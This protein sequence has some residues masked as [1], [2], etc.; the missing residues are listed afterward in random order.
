MKYLDKDGLT[1]LWGKIKAKIPTKTSQLTNDSGFSTF[2]GSYN[3]LT[4]KPTIP[5]QLSAGSHIDITNNTIKNTGV[6][7]VTESDSN[8]ANGT[9]QVLTGTSGGDITVNV[10]VKG[11]NNAAYKNV[12]TAIGSGGESLPT[13]TAVKSFVEGKGYTTNTGTITKV[14]ANGTDVAS[15]GTANIPAASTSEYGVTK[16]SSAT[17]STSTVLA[18]TPSA[19]KSAYDLASTASSKAFDCEGNIGNMDN[20][21]GGITLVDA[22]NTRQEVLTSGENIKTIDNKSLLGSG[23]LDITVNSYSISTTEP[24]SANYINSLI[25][26]SETTEYRVGIWVDDK[27]IYRKTFHVS[28]LP[29]N[30]YVNI[31]HNIAN[32]DMITDIQGVMRTPSN[33]TT[34][35]INFAGTSALYGSGNALC[36]RADRTNLVIGDT[37]NWSVNEAYIHLY[38]TK[39]TD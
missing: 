12:S 7:S 35:P 29:D 3:D 13:S 5:A 16:L 33:G 4:N 11:L 17:N 28:S 30:N 2:S 6:W 25:R 21:I 1:Y 23:N 14:Q 34:V 32:I 24:Y 26:Y 38:Y 39:T 10:G 20:L 31:A 15:S 19:V 22:I 18:A 36:V 9:I 37:T 8:A 27:P